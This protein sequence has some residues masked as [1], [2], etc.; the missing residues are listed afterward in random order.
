MIT[1]SEEKPKPKPR[2]KYGAE[3]AT[4][5]IDGVAK[6]S[7]VNH[8]TVLF[9]IMFVFLT[10]TV[11]ALG[12]IVGW[13]HHEMITLK[14]GMDKATSAISSVRAEVDAQEL[15]RMNV[16]HLKDDVAVLKGIDR[17]AADKVEAGAK[18]ESE[19]RAQLANHERDVLRIFGILGRVR[20]PRN[21]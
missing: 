11:V 7:E 4:A 21:Q 15:D 1:S 16:A 19:I 18:A 17:L 14:A 5:E 6:V 12:A 2:R 3:L 13:Q 9:S 8:V 20:V 10:G